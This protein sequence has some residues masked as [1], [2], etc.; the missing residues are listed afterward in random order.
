MTDSSVS[1]LSSYVEETTVASAA[2]TAACEDASEFGLTIP[3]AMTGQLLS[4]LAAATKAQGVIAVTP[5]AGVVG[6]YLL[7]G[8]GDNAII[9][10][11]DPEPEHQKR[12]KVTF[13]EAGYSP[14]RIRFLP[15]RPLDVM[16]RL[17]NASYQLVY[18]EVSPLELKAFV[19]AAL[20]LLSA[21]GVLVL[22]DALLDGT[23]ADLSR[24]DRDTVAAREADEY[25][26]SLD[27]VI[28]SRLPLGAG[29]TM[30]T[31]L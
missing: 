16:G 12:A 4:T 22:A 19:D 17:A 2:L 7:A 20:P 23:L 14:S 11:I 27:G 6:L 25:I 31:K 10:C 13:R 18:G 30:I 3:D 9:S 28:V 1:A 8:L 24:K 26:R 29:L 5:A 21:G 15:S